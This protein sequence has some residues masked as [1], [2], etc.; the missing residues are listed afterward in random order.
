[1]FH[2]TGPTPQVLPHSNDAT[3]GDTIRG[4]AGVNGQEARRQSSQPAPSPKSLS[5]SQ[6][7]VSQLVTKLIPTAAGADIW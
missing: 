4:V 3:I 5:V 2:Q 7:F 1:M 6:Q